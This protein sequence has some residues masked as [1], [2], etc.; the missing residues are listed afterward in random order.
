M[1]KQF[2]KSIAGSI[3]NTVGQPV[4]PQ[5]LQLQTPSLEKAEQYAYE[6]PVD[7]AANLAMGAGTVAKVAKGA[8]ILGKTGE[9]G[10]VVKASRYSF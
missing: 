9:A 3:N 7:V 2:I 5:T 8:G 10:K 6:K 1:T 4:N